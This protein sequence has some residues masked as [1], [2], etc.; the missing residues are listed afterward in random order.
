MHKIIWMMSVSLD[1]YMEGPNH[2]LDWQTVDDELHQHFN[3]ELRA[4]GAFLEG[5]R[6]YELMAGFWPTADADPDAPAPVAEFAGIWRDKRKYVFSR[7]L[8]GREWN[9]TVV[10]DV[11]PGE[12]R[13]LGDAVGDLFVGGAELAAAFQRHDLID[14]YRM[15]VHPVI[16]GEGTPMFAPSHGRLDLR[17]VE[18]RRFG[19]GVVLLRYDRSR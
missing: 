2:D 19:T 4:A 13:A 17:L 12:I 10:R 14:E 11:V 15:Y 6:T 8:D 9:T 16:I 3:D 18:N 7:T 1:G 5:R